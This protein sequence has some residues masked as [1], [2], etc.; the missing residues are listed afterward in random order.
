MMPT[1]PCL[2]KALQDIVIDKT[3]QGHVVEGL[4]EAIEALPDSYDALY[5]MAQKLAGL[6]M[7]PDWRFVEPNSLEEIWAE[8]DPSRP[9]GPIAQVDPQAVAPRVETAFLSSVCGCILGKPLE[10]NPTLDEIRQAAQKVG[11]WPLRDYI[12]PELLTALG[13]RHRSAPE[14]TRDRISYAAADDDLN[15]TVLGML[16]VEAHG[17]EFTQRHLADLWL[18]NLPLGWCWGP[19]RTLNLKAGMYLG[20]S[21]EAGI[22]IDQWAAVLNPFDEACGALIRADAYG[23]ACPGNPALAAELAWRDASFTHRRTGIYGTMFAA[24]SIAAAFVARDPIEIFEVAV[25]FVPQRSRFA[26]VV[27]DSI[28]MVRQAKD[29]LEGYGLIHGKYSQYRHCQIY[30][31]I[32]T[33]INTL[34][35]A[36]DI[37]DGLCM[38]VSQG[39]DTDSFGCTCGSILGAYFG[40]GR[41]DAKWLAPFHDTIHVGMADF[42][43]Q[44][45]SAVARRMGQL[46]ARIAAKTT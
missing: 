32:G 27:R 19:E 39:N 33:V 26:E 31:E 15:Y 3:R 36:P 13:R 6:P 10:V 30:Q 44:R 17:R 24:A 21:P 9:K 38:Q 16:L 11:Q 20:F 14:T 25:K 12:S 42:H 34:R 5:V 28:Q 29:W 18:K 23:Y 41:L 1:L 46:P 22:P 7:R 2:R 37:G 40:P 4:K 43:E 45:L 35:F 8:C